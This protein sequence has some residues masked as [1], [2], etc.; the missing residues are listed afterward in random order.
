MRCRSIQRCSI[1]GGL[2]VSVGPLLTA[3]AHSG[4]TKRIPTPGSVIGHEVG[5]AYKLA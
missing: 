3:V 2:I 1:A 5:A 4:R